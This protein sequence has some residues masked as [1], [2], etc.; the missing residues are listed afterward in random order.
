MDKVFSTRLDEQMIEEMER[1]A[2]RL[3]ITKKEFLE[4]AIRLRARALDAQSDSDVWAAT[5]GAWVRPEAAAGTFQAARE[6]F[7]ASFRR[8]HVLR[9]PKPEVAVRR[10]WA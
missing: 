2:K 10:A 3:G 5:S 6:V 4:S 1:V 8:H 9:A 7:E